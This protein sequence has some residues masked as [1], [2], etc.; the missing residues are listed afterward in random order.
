MEALGRADEGMRFKQQA[1]ARNPESWLVYAEIANSCWNQR[2]YDEA[3]LW[4]NRVLEID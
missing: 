4:A 1:L 3:M 2:R